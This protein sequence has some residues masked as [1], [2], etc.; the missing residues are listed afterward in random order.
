MIG[1]A[2]AHMRHNVVAYMALFVALGGTGAFAATS[3]IGP[4][5]QVNGCVKKKGK[6]KGTLRVV[7]PGKHCKRSETAIAWNQRGVPGSRGIRGP[8]GPGGSP[9]T[10]AQTLGKVKQVDGSGSG[11]DSDQ[12]DGHDT[13]FFQRRGSTTACTAGSKVTGIDAG[14]DVNCA[15][16]D[17]APTGPAGGDLLG[18]SYPNP[19]IK[20]GAVSADK[21]GSFPFSHWIGTYDCPGGSVGNGVQE[22]P[23]NT[24]TPVQ[25]RF[26]S[27]TT[28][29]AFGTSCTLGRTLHA[30][31]AGTY[32]ITS[33]LMWPSNPTG[34]RGLDIRVDGVIVASDRRPAA[35]DGDTHSNVSTV[36]RVPA[37]GR[38]RV[39]AY[40][41][42]GSSLPVLAGTSDARNFISAI[43]LGN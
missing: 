31:R 26:S 33:G 35:A 7:A 32:L 24:E 40:Q 10:P 19:T 18:S 1:R 25:W 11:L 43:W 23:N 39:V 3:L 8:R 37:D 15:A 29:W 6:R 30:P 12:L 34:R 36:V 27:P 41:T 17:T 9:D 4:N 16:D 42:S 14:G 20:P 22:I 13:P 5:H 28:D 21:L 38:I 2:C